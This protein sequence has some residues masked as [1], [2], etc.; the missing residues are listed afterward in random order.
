M[1]TLR[2][3]VGTLALQEQWALDELQQQRRPV[4]ERLRACKEHHAVQESALNATGEQLSRL[5]RTRT[6]NPALANLAR[7]QWA[8]QALSIREAA[9]RLEQLENEASVLHEAEV[10]AQHRLRL[11]QDEAKRL[12]RQEAKLRED[13]QAT[14]LDDL[15]LQQHWGQSN[16]N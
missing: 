8:R 11:L 9:D 10:A 1:S 5:L 15:W 6:F 13:A 16:G 4:E 3:A 7:R 2:E 14:A 12:R